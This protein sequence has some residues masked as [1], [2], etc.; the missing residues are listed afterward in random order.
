MNLGDPVFSAVHPPKGI[1]LKGQPARRILWALSSLLM[2][3]DNLPQL[4]LC[5]NR[6]GQGISKLSHLVQNLR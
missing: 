1:W 5:H 3:L 4:T 2:G 6:P